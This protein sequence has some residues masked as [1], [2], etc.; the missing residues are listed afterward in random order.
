M[1]DHF[2]TYFVAVDVGEA[3]TGPLKEHLAKAK[4]EDEKVAALRRVILA[5]LQSQYYQ[6]C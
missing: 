2:I 1:A 6:V 3:F 4:T 5:V